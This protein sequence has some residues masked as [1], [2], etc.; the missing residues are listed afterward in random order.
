MCGRYSLASADAEFSQLRLTFQVE[1]RLEL[2]PRY[3]IAPTWAPGYEPPIVFQTREAGR[4]LAL[5]R[6][7]MIPGNWARPLNALPASF[8]ARSEEIEQKPFWSRSFESRRCLVPSTGWSEF[9][10][11]RGQR[12]AFQFHYDHGLFALA[13]VW[14]RWTSP[15]GEEV[16]SFAIVTV[17]AND[18][19]SPVHDRM[20]L[21]VDPALY[22][23]WLDP[24]LSGAKALAAVRP[25]PATLAVYEADALGNDIRREGPECIAPVKARQ[26]GLFS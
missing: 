26:L 1:A 9:N 20:P 6:W 24:E 13:G 19:V 3:N 5:A 21:C 18:I 10:G 22:G 16:Q 2:T 23:V 7:W 11:P 17:A 12:R 14:D 25:P 15:G 8:N 4:Q